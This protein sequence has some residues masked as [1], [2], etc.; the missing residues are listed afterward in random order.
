[1]PHPEKSSFESALE[2]KNKIDEAREKVKQTREEMTKANY[3]YSRATAELIRILQD[4]HAENTAELQTEAEK[5]Y[6]DLLK[7]RLKEAVDKD[8]YE[9]MSEIVAK[10]KEFKE[11]IGQ[12]NIPEVI[13]GGDLLSQELGYFIERNNISDAHLEH[14]RNRAQVLATNNPDF[15]PEEIIEALEKEYKTKPPKTTGGW[16]GHHG[17]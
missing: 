9:E 16:V 4:A 10:L 17:K 8:D 6:F 15:S 3:D 14:Y 11:R 7:D 12:T 1:M 5:E 13:E 2:A